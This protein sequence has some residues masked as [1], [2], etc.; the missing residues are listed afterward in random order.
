MV[1]DEIDAAVGGHTPP[2]A[3]E[4]L[5]RVA[6]QKQVLCITHLPQIASMADRHIHIEKKPVGHRTQTFVRVLPEPERL[7][8]LARMIGGDPITK[9]GL[10]N[11]AEMVRTA[12]EFKQAMHQARDKSLK[13]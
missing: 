5:A 13:K 3:A 11:A 10:E 1:F 9:A 8:E 7:N 12:A 6:W 4:K 2:T